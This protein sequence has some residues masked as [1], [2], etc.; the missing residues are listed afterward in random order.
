MPRAE[1]SAL[2]YR[3]L[4]RCSALGVKLW[5]NNCGQLQAR[6]GQW[7]RYGVGNPGGSDL[8]GYLPVVIGPEHVGRTLAV[9]VAIE[10]KT[11]TGT[12]R[13]EQAQFL[14]V[15]GKHGAIT[16]LAR[17]ESDAEMALAPWQQVQP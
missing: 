4:L 9:F 7:V 11:A 15:A 13:A 5:R 16:C 14:N 6:N 10:A 17:S 8:I 3:L 12:L 1:E 2:L